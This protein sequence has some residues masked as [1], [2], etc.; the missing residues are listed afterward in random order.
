MDAC[1]DLVGQS[2]VV[3]WPL[4]SREY[5]AVVLGY[6]GKTKK[7]KLY[8]HPT[9]KETEQVELLNLSTT[10]RTWKLID[11]DESSH[12]K[13]V[14]GDDGDSGP[15]I[16][17]RIGVVWPD[18]RMRPYVCEAVVVAHRGVETFRVVYVDDDYCEDRKLPSEPDEDDLPWR[19]LWKNEGPTPALRSTIDGFHGGKSS[20]EDEEKKKSKGGN[21]E[22]GELEPE[23]SANASQAMSLK[24]R[25]QRAFDVWLDAGAALGDDPM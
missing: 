16:G 23:P 8:Y 24:D 5:E 22:D 4:D 12:R 9:D 7:H 2:V 11:E 10:D 14:R 18:N 3:N 13:V 21:R 19:V 20:D 15:P 25:L 6:D 1:L 17:S